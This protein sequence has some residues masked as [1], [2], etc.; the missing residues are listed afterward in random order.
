[1]SATLAANAKP[2]KVD[3][4]PLGNVYVTGVLS[5][6]GQYESNFNLPDEHRWMADLTNGQVE[7]QKIDGPSAPRTCAR[8]TPRM[9][10][11]GVCRCGT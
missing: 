6:M 3:A 7:V 5:V 10:F 8:A 4:G 11:S 9:T 2:L 1:M